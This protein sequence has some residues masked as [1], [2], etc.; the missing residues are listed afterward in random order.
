MIATA[1]SPGTQRD[2]RLFNERTGRTT[3]AVGRSGDVV[4]P[5]KSNLNNNNYYYYYIIY[6]CVFDALSRVLLSAPNQRN[7]HRLPAYS[8]CHL[9]RSCSLT[10]PI[11][12][13]YS[14]PQQHALS[15]ILLLLRSCTSRTTPPGR[16][17]RLLLHTASSQPAASLISETEE[18]V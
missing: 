3:T 4:D 14:S 10:P 13:S 11:V 1:T 9:P 6:P 15:A 16:D 7:E 12:T 2:E 17:N 5:Y 8:S 18:R